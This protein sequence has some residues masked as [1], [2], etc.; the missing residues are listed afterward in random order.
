MPNLDN[1]RERMAL[2][3]ELAKLLD[4]CPLLDNELNLVRGTNETDD[5]GEHRT[6][7]KRLIDVLTVINNN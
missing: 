5:E 7:A 4:S 2:A 3:R 6:A 1:P